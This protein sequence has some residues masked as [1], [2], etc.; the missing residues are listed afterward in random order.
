PRSAAAP[1]AASASPVPAPIPS[2]EA[3]APVQLDAVPQTMERFQQLMSRFLD[4]QKSVMLAYLGT[5]QNGFVPV[6]QQAG[7]VPDIV[8]REPEPRPMI[9]EVP[10][11]VNGTAPVFDKASL[12]AKLISI[13]SDRTGYPAEMLGLNQDLE[14]DLGIDS[15]KRVEILGTF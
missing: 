7:G 3:A 11:S 9:A 13:V 6:V 8:S 10:P 12:T 2:V 1:V 14:A 15:I 4:T 5:E